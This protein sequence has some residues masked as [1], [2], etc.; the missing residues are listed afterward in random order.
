VTYI[1]FFV[2]EDIISHNTIDDGENNKCI[3][4]LFDSGGLYVE[5]CSR[6]R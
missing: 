6:T 1:S 2:G 5:S 3:F 4:Y